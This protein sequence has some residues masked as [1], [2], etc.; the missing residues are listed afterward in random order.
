MED[1]GVS[2]EMARPASI[3]WEWMRLI[4]SRWSAV[5]VSAV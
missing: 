1:E 3:E 5:I 4:V 2:G